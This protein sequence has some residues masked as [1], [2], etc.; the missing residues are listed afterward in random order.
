[1]RVFLHVFLWAVSVC[2]ETW[3]HEM[4][5]MLLVLIFRVD[6]KAL[7]VCVLIHMCVFVSQLVCHVCVCVCICVVD[8]MG[9][10]MLRGAL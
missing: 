1:M 6:P 8:V 4:Q 5:R 2:N 10:C 3:I 9:V 7:Y